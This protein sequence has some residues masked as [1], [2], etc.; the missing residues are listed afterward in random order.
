VGDQKSEDADVL[1]KCSLFR[2]LDR[3]DLLKLASYSKRKKIGP[4]EP[5]FHAGDTGES[6]IGVVVGQVRI[7]RTSSDGDTIIINDF[8]A[9]E[10][11]GEI[12]LLDGGGRSADAT[13]LTNC[14]LIVLERREFLPFLRDRPELCIDLLKTL[15]AKVRL[16][17]E[18]SS[19]FLFHDLESR[20]ARALLRLCAQPEASGRPSKTALSQGELAQ[21]IGATRPNVNRQIKEWERSGILEQSK[22][23]IILR[24]RED[25]DAIAG[26]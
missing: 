14:E 1:G 24:R 22:G 15:C 2:G 4:G 17:D 5:I 11:F 7:S 13:T 21:I 16:A 18:R 12:A 3:L 8:G 26:L 6:L 23:W 25:L 9:G 10:L 19:D 20:L